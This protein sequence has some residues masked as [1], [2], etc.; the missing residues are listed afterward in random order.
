MRIR[1]ADEADLPD[2]RRLDTELFPAL[3][4]PHFVLRQLLEL[5]PDGLFVLEDDASL[6][7]YILSATTEDSTEAWILSLGVSE[8]LRGRG[9]GR[10]LMQQALRNLRD[11]GVQEVLLTV[12]PANAAAI[13]LYMSLGFTPQGHLK[14]YFGPGH[15]RLLLGRRL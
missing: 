1:H 3:A 4:Y 11:A 14:D 9:Q 6:H 5:H 13:A 12:E 10:R 7:G 15:D 2:L 8:K